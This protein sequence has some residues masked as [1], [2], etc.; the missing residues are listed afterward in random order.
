MLV[1]GQ[2]QTQVVSS[3]LPAAGSSCVCLRKEHRCLEAA[4]EVQ[5]NLG[6]VRR[7]TVIT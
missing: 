3:F 6:G 2:A 7:I 4:D 5:F 1:R